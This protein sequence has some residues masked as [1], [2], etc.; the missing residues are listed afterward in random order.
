MRQDANP[1]ARSI[2]RSTAIVVTRLLSVMPVATSR[3]AA[4]AA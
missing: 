1:L 3:L 2:V 4:V